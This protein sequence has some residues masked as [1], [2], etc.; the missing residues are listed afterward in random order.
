MDIYAIRDELISPY[1]LDPKFEEHLPII[2]AEVYFLFSLKKVERLIF[3]F[4]KVGYVNFTWQSGIRKYVYHFDK[5]ESLNEH[6]LES[7]QISIPT[8]G[9]IPKR[10]KGKICLNIFFYI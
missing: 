4:L 5:L 10:P 8:R 2:P 1:I 3:L 9:R 7:P 6:I